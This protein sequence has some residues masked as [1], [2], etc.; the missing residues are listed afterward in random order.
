VRGA[1]VRTLVDGDLGR[2]AHTV[3]WNGEDD[4]GRLVSSGV[5]YY[6]LTAG[7]AT[8]TRRMVLLK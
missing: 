2:G 5:Y 7:D 3:D 1:H 4:A 6:R 8:A